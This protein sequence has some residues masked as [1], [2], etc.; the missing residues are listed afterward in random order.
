MNS[1]GHRG[2]GTCK[3][4]RHFLNVSRKLLTAKSPHGCRGDTGEE[5]SSHSSRSGTVLDECARRIVSG[6][7]NILGIIKPDEDC[8]FRVGCR[9]CGDSS[10]PVTYWPFN[11]NRW[12]LRIRVGLTKTEAPVAA[13]DVLQQ[14]QLG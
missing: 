9:A 3:P 4:Q 13:A 2:N 10:R 12:F 6:I 8:W 7:E 1:L 14:R 5:Y 11:L